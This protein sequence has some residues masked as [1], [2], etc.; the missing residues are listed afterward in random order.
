[1]NQ[2]EKEFFSKKKHIG[3]SFYLES[4]SWTFTELW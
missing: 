2:R 3:C 1:M 4:K